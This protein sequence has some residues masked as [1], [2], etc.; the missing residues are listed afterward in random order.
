ME[1]V[2]QTSR[3]S[4]VEAGIMRFATWPSYW[5]LPVSFGLMTVMMT[6]RVAQVLGGRF[7]DTPHDP[8]EELTS[9][10]DEAS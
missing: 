10:P 6:L 1:A 3:G 4:Y 7:N 5:I 8:L 2:S 9:N